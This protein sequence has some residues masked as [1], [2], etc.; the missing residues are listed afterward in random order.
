LTAKLLEGDVRFAL[1][2]TMATTKQAIAS[3]GGL[4]ALVDYLADDYELG[5]R[6]RDKGYRAVIARAIV[7]T[8]LPDYDFKTFLEH[9]LRWGRTVRSS[10]PGGYFGMIT[11]FG[12]MWALIVVLLDRNIFPGAFVASPGAWVLLFGM[13]GGKALVTWKVGREVIGDR[14]APKNLWLLPFRE[15]ITPLI[16]LMSWFGNKIVWRGETFTLRD[17]KLHR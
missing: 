15:L 16:W 2:S 11:T 9:Q 3:I 8:F 7:E 13:L 10:R 12:P 14:D 4:E 5:K 6:I 17:G 1:G